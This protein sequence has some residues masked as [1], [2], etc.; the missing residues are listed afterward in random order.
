MFKRPVQP[1]LQL[2]LRFGGTDVRDS[3]ARFRDRLFRGNQESAGDR[4]AGRPSFVWR[5]VCDELT[6]AGRE[7]YSIACRCVSLPV[8]SIRQKR[9]RLRVKICRSA[10]VGCRRSIRDERTKSAKPKSA[11]IAAIP[12]VKMISPIILHSTHGMPDGFVV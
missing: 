1:A 2:K 3:A 12:I 8:R 9:P 10:V 6:Y 4:L 11:T 7:R 5:R